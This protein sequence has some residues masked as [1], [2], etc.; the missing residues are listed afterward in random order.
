VL[1]ENVWE[2]CTLVTGLEVKIRRTAKPET[3][4]LNEKRCGGT[5]FFK[6]DFIISMLTVN[7]QT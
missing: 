5:L 2:E 3:R 6:K 4:P 7:N 1:E